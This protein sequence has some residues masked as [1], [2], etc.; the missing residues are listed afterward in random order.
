MK[1]FLISKML[2]ILCLLSLMSPAKG[3]AC[4]KCAREEANQAV[5]AMDRSAELLQGAVFHSFLMQKV[6]SRA[7]LPCIV[8][9]LRKW[10]ENA[11]ARLTQSQRESTEA[12]FHAKQAFKH[13]HGLVR[14]ELLVGASRAHAQYVIGRE[15]AHRTKKTTESIKRELAWAQ[16]R[17]AEIVAYLS[18]AGVERE[19]GSRIIDYEAALAEV[20]SIL[21]QTEQRSQASDPQADS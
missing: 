14:P 4:L 1:P 18:Q 5:A 20:E 11:E 12:D 19:D 10:V 17:M 9:Y 2:G 7:C 8:G 6:R 15:A 21:S 16:E 13:Y 3:Y